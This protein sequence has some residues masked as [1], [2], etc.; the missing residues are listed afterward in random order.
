M[1]F[2]LVPTAAFSTRRPSSPAKRMLLITVYSRLLSTKP[3]G[4]GTFY[5]KK[6]QYSLVGSD[7]VMVL[8]G[9]LVKIMAQA[10]AEKAKDVI[11]NELPPAV[12]LSLD[13]I[14]VYQV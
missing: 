4:P 1:R 8:P 10:A 6:V 3:S 5:S 11:S 2:K 12:E 9:G 13:G 7:E 14:Y